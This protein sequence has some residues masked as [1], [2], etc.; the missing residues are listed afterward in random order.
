MSEN[1]IN[2]SAFFRRRM[3]PT[4]QE[5]KERNQKLLLMIVTQLEMIQEKEFTQEQLCVA[6]TRISDFISV[7]TVVRKGMDRTD[8]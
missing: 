2:R 6:L 4:D 8:I 5:Y 1:I 3:K 7:E